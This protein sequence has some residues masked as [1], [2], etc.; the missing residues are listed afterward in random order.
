LQ[1]PLKQRR[2]RIHPGDPSALEAAAQRGMAEAG[3][4]QTEFRVVLP[5]GPL[6]ALSGAG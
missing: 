5:D 6:D 2:E 4:L 1:V 3:I